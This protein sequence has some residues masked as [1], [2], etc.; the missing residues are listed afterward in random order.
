MNNQQKNETKQAELT[1]GLDKTSQGQYHYV[2]MQKLSDG[3]DGGKGGSP[4]MRV[5]DEGTWQI[6]NSAGHNLI[7][8]FEQGQ[9]SGPGLYEKFTGANPYML[10]AVQNCVDVRSYPEGSQRWTL[11][12]G[13]IV[14]IFRRWGADE[15]EMIHMTRPA[16]LGGGPASNE[17]FTTYMIHMGFDGLWRYAHVNTS[18]IYCDE[19][20]KIDALN[21]LYAWQKYMTLLVIRKV[22]ADAVTL[23]GSLQDL[24]SHADRLPNEGMMMDMAHDLGIVAQL[25]MNVIEG[26]V[27]TAMIEKTESTEKS[28]KSE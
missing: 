13:P 21:A 18:T 15:V 14:D 9:L 6:T 19:Q 28:S 17:A 2:L 1:L 10:K 23:A 12:S 11:R 27:P 4:M 7:R 25:I 5:L 24:L 26:Y 16:A 3:K 8:D 22:S 20:N